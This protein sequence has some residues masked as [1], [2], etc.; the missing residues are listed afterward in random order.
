MLALASPKLR[1][2][3]HYCKW[4]IQVKTTDDYCNEQQN[5]VYAEYSVLPQIKL[6]Y[7]VLHQLK[8]QYAGIIDKIVLWSIKKTKVDFITVPIN[9]VIYLHSLLKM[10]SVSLGA[11]SDN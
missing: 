9:L 6:K 7:S 3:I 10:C 11:R 4:Y 5:I 8:Y 2:E 1:A